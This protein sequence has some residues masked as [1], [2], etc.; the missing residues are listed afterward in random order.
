[1]HG[2]ISPYSKAILKGYSDEKPRRLSLKAKAALISL[3]SEQNLIVR[4]K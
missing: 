4:V 3:F 2:I 1:V